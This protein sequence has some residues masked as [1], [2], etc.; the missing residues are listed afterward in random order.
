MGAGS[1]KQ[2]VNTGFSKN[3]GVL[4]MGSVSSLGMGESRVEFAIQLH[5]SKVY[6]IL[7]LVSGWLWHHYDES[8]DLVAPREARGCLALP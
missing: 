1:S 2:A 8:N 4:L 5:T 7:R 6:F 3:E